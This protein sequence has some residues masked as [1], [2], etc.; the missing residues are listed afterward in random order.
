VLEIPAWG[1]GGRRAPPAATLIITACAGFPC[2]ASNLHEKCPQFFAQTIAQ[3]VARLEQQAHG[4][5]ISPAT[6]N[7][8]HE[9]SCNF[10]RNFLRN[11][12]HV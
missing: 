10:L 11:Q 7:N 4:C 2:N 8:L 3:S 1:F 5:W 12:L 6:A 9:N